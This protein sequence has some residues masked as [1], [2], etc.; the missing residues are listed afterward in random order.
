MKSKKMISVGLISISILSMELILTRIFSAEFFYTFSFLILSLAVMG[1]SLGSLC[2]R[3]FKKLND[4][5][6]LGLILSASALMGIISPILIFVLKINFSILFYSFA[7]ILKFL[8]AITLLSSTFFWG[9]MALGVIFRHNHQNMPKIYLADMAGAGFAV[10]LS[11]FIMNTFG[12]QYATFL[13]IVPMLIAA[14][15]NSQKL[16]KTIPVVLFASVIAIMPYSDNL[17]EAKRK[18]HG[19]VIYKHWDA[20]SKI[21]V[22]DFGKWGRGLNI[23]N[24]ANSP[25]I[26]FN[27]DYKGLEWKIDVGNMVNQ[28]DNCCFLSLGAGGGKDVLQALQKG[29]TEIHAVEVNPHINKMMVSGH[30][31]GYIIPDSVK[32]N[33]F[34]IVTSNDYS[35]NI[36]NDPKVKVISEDARTY[37][38]RFKNKFDI[39]YSLSSN[40]WAALGSGSFAFAE[41]YIFTSEAFI[42]YWNALSENGYL[43][44]E[45]QIY[46]P[47]IVSSAID[48]LRK[49][50]VKNPEKHIAVYNLPK[51]RRKLLLV[52]KMPLTNELIYSLYGKLDTKNHFH[53]DVLYPLPDSAKNNLINKIVNN[54]W[55]KLADKIPVD[56][57]PSTDDRP[58]VA[59]M[60]LWKNFE[61]KKLKKTSIMS[62]FSGFPLT[63]I[64]LITILIIIIIIIIPLNLLPYIFSREKLKLHPWLFFFA[65]GVGYMIVEIVLI[66]KTSLYIGASFYSIAT[67]L[68]VMLLASGIGSKYSLN[69]SNRTIFLS[70]AILIPVIIGL[71]QLMVNTMSGLPIFLRSFSTAILIFPLGFFM[72]MPFPK[73][74]KRVGELVDW[75]FAVN[76]AA[77]VFGATIVMV[78]VFAIGFN[79]TLVIGSAIYL[80]AYL[81]FA[82]KKW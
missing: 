43:S 25:L 46:M 32:K 18:E 23:D 51:L 15:I 2:L 34:K 40:T 75:G 19:P 50:G 63:K 38:K 5:K 31:S 26:P 14:Y 82:S 66:Q 22:Y 13:L 45:H 81:L 39:I 67:V 80:L 33:T 47:R 27:G 30:K 21:K 10:L 70:I 49:S 11:L 9:G 8:L 54:G 78:L 28:F 53:K 79:Y 56:I 61:W 74:S 12:T 76:G 60:G 55:Q 4:P 73:A 65:I 37:I 57:S 6:K 41:N 44:M 36:Y 69:F 68:F 77:S 62:D 7:E 16:Q 20:M 1:L 24:I 35:G 42:D 64:L 29:A 58:F 48:G 3:F 71:F 72:G 52:S 17:L 59:Q